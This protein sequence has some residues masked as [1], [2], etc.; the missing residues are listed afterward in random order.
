M[1]VNQRVVFD[2]DGIRISRRGSGGRREPPKV[3]IEISRGF[4][5]EKANR[6]FKR[7][8]LTIDELFDLTE[9]LDDLCDFIEDNE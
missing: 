5:P 9:A 4:G 7:L 8:D 3:I 6:E 1:S 2:Q